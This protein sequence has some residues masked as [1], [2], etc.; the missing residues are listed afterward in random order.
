MSKLLA[1]AALSGAGLMAGIGTAEAAA[2]QP[3]TGWTK[4]FVTAYDSPWNQSTVMFSLDADT[5]V[6]TYCFRE[7]QILDGDPRWFIINAK[8]ASAYVHIGL[9]SVNQA[10]VSHC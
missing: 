8:G 3:V 5:P 7:G 4:A 6:D 10:E 9:I 2:S 1:V